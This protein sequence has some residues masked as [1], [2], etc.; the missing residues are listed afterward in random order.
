MA[1]IDNDI[2]VL[3]ELA[4]RYTQIALT[5][6]MRGLEY[7]TRAHNGL[8]IVRPLVNVFEVPWG[9]LTSEPDLVLQCAETHARMLEQRLR[10]TLYQHK[11]F[12]ADLTLP[13]YFLVPVSLTGTGY[14]LSIDESVR[15]SD[16]GSD[17]N[18]HSYND[19]LPDIESLDKIQMPCVG[20]NETE[21]QANLHIA[22][23]AFDGLMPVTMGGVGLYSA[24]WDIIPMLHGPN[25]V[26]EDLIDNP[27]YCHAAVNKFAEYFESLHQ[28]YEKLNVLEGKQY[29][30]HC[31]PALTD[32]LPASDNDGNHVRLKDVWARG[33][34]QIFAVVSPSMHDEFDLKYMKRL[35]DPCGLSYYGCCEPLDRKIGLLRKRFPNLRKISITPWA[36]VQ[37]AAEEIGCD[38]VLSYKPNPGNVANEYNP[39]VV[40]SE[41]RN[42]LT[43]CKTNGTPCEIILKDISTIGGDVTRLSRWVDTVNETIDQFY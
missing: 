33:M 34:A 1:I 28:Q 23:Q 18:S 4:H 13:P 6:R 41:I 25:R 3:R 27:E 20:I 16:T 42:V 11:H 15:H 29:Y 26:I 17:I 8:S 2:L 43:A 22:K 5:D 21:N 12:M 7:R 19:Q 39:D 32:E 30:V 31:T 35:F 38:Y 36:N 9:E 40:R 24:M 10:M 14:G 37:H